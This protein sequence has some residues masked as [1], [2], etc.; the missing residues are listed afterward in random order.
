MN[1]YRYLVAF[2]ACWISSAATLYLL[3]ILWPL[4]DVIPVKSLVIKTFFMSIV[5]LIIL[6]AILKKK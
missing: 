6:L 2:I 1:K 4:D 5:I 3:N